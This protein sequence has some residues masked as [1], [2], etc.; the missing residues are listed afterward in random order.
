M[1]EFAKKVWNKL[2]QPRILIPCVVVVFMMV[3]GIGVWIYLDAK[4]NERIDAEAITFADTLEVEF[5]KSAKVSDFLANL[6]GELVEDKSIATDLLGEQE[7]TFEYINI[8]NK[9]RQRSFTVKVVDKTAPK[10][11]GSNAY[12]VSLGYT[13][14]LTCLILSGDDIDDNPKREIL[15]EY[16]VNEEGSYNL[17]YVITDASGN[18]AKQ[19]FVLNVVKPDPNAKPVTYTAEKLAL[20][21]VIKKHK[22]SQAKIGIDVS[23]W[24]GEIDWQKV[25]EAGVEFA[26]IRLGYQVEYDGEY[27]LDKY[28]ERNIQNATAVDL[29]VGV[30]F[31]SFANST[32]EAERQAK[33]IIEQ[34]KDYDVELGVAF[35]WENWSD[36]N[37]AGMSFYTI[38]QVAKTFLDT[39]HQSGYKGLLYSSKNYLE[40]IWQPLAYDTWL[41]QYY[42]RVTYAGDYKIWQMSSSGQVP[43]IYG[44]VDLDIMCLDDL[45]A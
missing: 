26:F 11:Y 20:E 38:N 14:D 42:D 28:F 31:Y 25:K 27:Y 30:Y 33:W 24:Q 40:R 3:V 36:F 5:G 35:D 15:G 29:P 41:A 39:V 8:K 34:L 16:D 23:A 13:G 12:T 1:K 45:D 44:D 37:N 10:I 21:D 17:E 6:N 22:N 19:D 32:S 18:S 9:K 7:V 43:G 4:E 2:K